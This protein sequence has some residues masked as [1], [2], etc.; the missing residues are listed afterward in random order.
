LRGL[1]NGFL[2]NQVLNLK[3]ITELERGNLQSAEAN[4][5][6]CLTIAR[7]LKDPDTM[8]VGLERFA[9]LAAATHAPRRAAMLWGTTVRLREELGL[10]IPR[11]KG[12]RR[13][14]AAA[15]R[16]VLGDSA[17]DQAWREG[18][19]MELQEAVRY[20]LNRR[21]TADT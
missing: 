15:A 19:A 13:S 9:D 5:R 18:S 16:A 17:F 4:F 20:A 6:E 1:G 7:E 14:A 10:L 12:A 3:G 21:S 11:R 2:T 8:I